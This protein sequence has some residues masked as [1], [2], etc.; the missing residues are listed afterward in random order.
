M[1]RRKCRHLYAD[2]QADA[3]FF[4]VF[5]RRCRDCGETLSLGEAAPD[6]EAVRVEVHLA[7]LLAENRDL[8]PPGKLRDWQD[9][10][11]IDW[12]CGTTYYGDES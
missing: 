6:T 8:F 9:R 11:M 1:S 2:C 4:S 5:S 10:V 3:S 7:K 12:A